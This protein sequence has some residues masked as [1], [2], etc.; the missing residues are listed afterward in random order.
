MGGFFWLS[1]TTFL[2]WSRF[3]CFFLENLKTPK[4]HFEINWPLEP[5]QNT[6]RPKRLLYQLLV[7][8]IGDLPLKVLDD[9][10]LILNVALIFIIFCLLSGVRHRSWALQRNPVRSPIGREYRWDFLYWQRSPLWHLLPHIE[11]NHSHLWWSQPF[12]ISY[13]VRY[14]FFF[15]LFKLIKVI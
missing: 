15:I 5:S 4:G 2:I 8:R 12:S 14:I 3:R 1:Y 13:H 6:V 11:I 10:K 7:C 9:I